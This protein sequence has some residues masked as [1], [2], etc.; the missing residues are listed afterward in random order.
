[1]AQL[2]AQEIIN[3]RDIVSQLLRKSF[4][5]RTGADQKQIVQQ[6]RP[7]PKL[8]IHGNG[9]VFQAEWYSKKDWLC[10]IESRK[11]LFCWPCLL[12]KPG[13]SQ[14]WTETGYSNMR[15]FLSDCRKHEKAKS[16]FDSYKMWKTF[17]TGERVDVLFSR[18]R[19]DEIERHNEEVRQ[20]RDMLKIIIEAV[21][22]LAK[23]ELAF[24]S[25]DESNS[26]LNKGNYREL[27]ECLAKFDSIFERQL[28]GRLADHE[29]G[30]IQG[31]V[32]TGV[33]P[34]TQNDL[35]ECIDSVIQDQIDREIEQCTFLSIQIDEATDFSTKEQLSC[36]IRLD[37]EGEIV[38]RFLKFHDVSSDRTASSISTIVKM[39]L[40]RYGEALKNKLIMQTYDGASVMSG[41]ISGVQ[42][43]VRDDYPYAY[44]FHCAAHRLNLVLCQ[45]ASSISS[46]KVFFANV[47]AFSSFASVSSKR[48]SLLR[49]HGLDIPVPSETR[50]CY[51]SRTINVISE[52]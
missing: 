8:E 33:S 13:V 22:Y 51:R 45:S 12:F 47:G 10:G 37:K 48:K 40:H 14:T 32:F 6:P 34:D 23:Q 29:R 5:G 39:L 27:L 26:S 11:R 36:I 43:L 19:R 25:H 30:N 28:H 3:D 52:N 7:M 1:M 9:R 15:G 46:V 44:F 41:H 31:G 38:E 18:A 49:A 20:N 16:H 21:L 4:A 35:I 42:T 50:W 17:D 24:R 2:R